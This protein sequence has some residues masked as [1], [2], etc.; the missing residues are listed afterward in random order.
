MNK[1]TTLIIAL[2][3]LIGCATIVA[4]G[5]DRIPVNTNPPGAKIFLDG[6]LV[7]TS[8]MQLAVDRKDEAQ[9]RVELDG[10]EPVTIDR[11]KELNAWFIGNLLIGGLI[12]VTIDLITS[13][14]G[15]YAET[16][17]YLV[18]SPK[19]RS[20]S[21]AEDQIRVPLKPVS[22]GEQVQASMDPMNYKGY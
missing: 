5:P 3:T 8:P 12:G 1:P 7:G 4:P 2:I 9:V 11:D 6:R 15:K 14:Q 19:G 13:N 10:Y 18:L 22:S 20:V 16:P 21:S 17:I